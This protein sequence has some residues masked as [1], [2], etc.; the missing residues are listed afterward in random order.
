[1]L[2]HNKKYKQSILEGGL[3]DGEEESK[4]IGSQEKDTKATKDEAEI[5]S[6]EF[7]DNQLKHLNPTSTTSSLERNI[8]SAQEGRTAEKV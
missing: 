7:N 4:I 8:E 5:H 2:E 3:D 1:M 6:Y